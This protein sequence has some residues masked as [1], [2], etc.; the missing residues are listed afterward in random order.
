M[1]ALRA[2]RLQAG[3]TAERACF[4]VRVLEKLAYG[5]LAVIPIMPICWIPPVMPPMKL[6]GC[7]GA[8]EGEARHFDECDCRSWQCQMPRG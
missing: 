8:E 7:W 2:E 6:N 3:G 4:S 5:M 1:G